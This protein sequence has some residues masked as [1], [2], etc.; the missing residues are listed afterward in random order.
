MSSLCVDEIYNQRAF[1]VAGHLGVADRV[2]RPKGIVPAAIAVTIC[3]AVAPIGILTHLHLLTPGKVINDVKVRP[4]RL[5][6]AFRSQTLIERS[7]D[8][9]PD[10][11]TRLDAALRVRSPGIGAVFRK[12]CPRIMFRADVYT[13]TAREGERSENQEGLIVFHGPRSNCW[14]VAYW[15]TV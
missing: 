2:V 1:R 10:T 8:L 9:G 13:G 7:L 12:I 4:R 6:V 11:R 15:L 5:S 3:P 14:A